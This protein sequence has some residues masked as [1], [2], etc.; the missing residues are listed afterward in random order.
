RLD[1]LLE[2][3]QGFGHVAT[4]LTH[5]DPVGDITQYPARRLIRQAERHLRLAVGCVTQPDPATQGDPGNA[6][7]RQV[8]AVVE[9]DHLDQAPNRHRADLPVDGVA[10]THPTTLLISRFPSLEVRHERWVA[11]RVA[12]DLPH[13][14]AV[15]VDHTPAFD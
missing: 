8:A 15:G 4:Y 5:G 2:A 7:P 12:D 10:R 3:F 6:Y 11:V 9:F 1:E 13:R 14:A